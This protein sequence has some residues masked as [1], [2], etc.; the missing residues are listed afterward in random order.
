MG[1]MVLETRGLCKSYRDTQAL[2]D[3]TVS[4]EGNRIYGLLGRNGAGK[5]TLLNLITSRIFASAGE[6]RAFGQPAVENGKVLSRICYMP[7]KNL[8][9][10][11]MRVEEIIAVSAQFYE[12]FDRDFARSLC[13]KFRLSPRK[14]Y[15]DL[16]RG[17]ESILRIV[18]GLAS[19]APLTIFDEPVLG[20]DAAVRELFY[21]ELIADFT[22]NPRTVIVSTHLIEES[23]DVFSEVIIL[24]DGLLETFISTEELRESAFYLSGRAE[25]V[26]AATQGLRVLHTESVGSVCVSAVYGKPEPGAVKRWSGEGIDISPVPIQKLFIYLTE[27]EGGK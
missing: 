7:E 22:E 2:S 3:F 26:R 13:E 21:R 19:R 12:N 6:I 23:A 14:R 15:N 16:S 17:Y 10:S 27:T 25:A 11:K 20:L 4:L 1:D 5:T 18:I 8:F 24:R 9:I